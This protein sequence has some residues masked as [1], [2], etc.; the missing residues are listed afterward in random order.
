MR[1]ERRHKQKQNENTIPLINVVFLM[2]VF[3]LIAGTIAPSADGEINP[4]IS[5]LEQQSPPEEAISLRKDGTLFYRGIE[6]DIT[7]PLPATLVK[8]DHLFI[9]PDQNSNAQV[10]AEKV[11]R[12]KALS[13]K[14]I[15]ILIKRESE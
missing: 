7:A 12:L 8:A 3:F 1:L 11:A 15:S 5:G 13:S 14:P 6:L 10:F 4:V 9:Y 2:L